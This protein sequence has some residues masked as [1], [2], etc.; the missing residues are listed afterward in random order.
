MSILDRDVAVIRVRKIWLIAIAII[1]LVAI[2]G[3]FHIYATDNVTKT[4]DETIKR[5][6]ILRVVPMNRLENPA[7]R[8]HRV[9]LKV[10]NP[11][12]STVKITLTNIQVSIDEF[13]V[14]V[15]RLGTEGTINPGKHILFEVDIAIPESLLLEFKSRSVVTV[16][17]KGEIKATTNF[18]WVERTKDQPLDVSMLCSSG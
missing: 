12:S 11:T 9:I 6:E 15:T 10:E 16:H 13:S 17:V 4:L 3:G 2:L 5:V 7:R 14:E 8:V 18:L 1:I